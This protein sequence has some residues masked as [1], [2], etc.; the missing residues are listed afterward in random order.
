MPMN[1]PRKDEVEER[2]EQHLRGFRPVV[3]SALAIPSRRAPW[4]VLAAAAGILVVIALSLVLK[5][6]WHPDGTAVAR[7]PEPTMPQASVPIPI[8]LSTL[9]AAL[10]TNDQELNKMLNDV[11]PRLLPRQHRGTALFELGKE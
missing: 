4:G 9:N 7:R 3:P 2:F 10:R 11:S 1:E 5:R 6:N 8:T